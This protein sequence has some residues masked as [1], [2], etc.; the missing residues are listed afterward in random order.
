[1]TGKARE[2]VLPMLHRVKTGSKLYLPSFMHVEKSSVYR[3][4]V[5]AVHLRTP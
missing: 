3:Q 1:M 4:K 5:Y 2:T